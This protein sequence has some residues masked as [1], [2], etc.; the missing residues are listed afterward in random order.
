MRVPLDH[1]EVIRDKVGGTHT[2]ALEIA[3]EA[4][5]PVYLVEE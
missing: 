5:V 1:I 3:S 2:E 4:G